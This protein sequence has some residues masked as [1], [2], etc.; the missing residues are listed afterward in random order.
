MNSLIFT[1]TCNFQGD[2]VRVFANDSNKITCGEFKDIKIRC[3]NSCM[4]LVINS[5]VL[6]SMIMQMERC[7]RRLM[8]IFLKDWL[9]LKS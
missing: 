8:A 5:Y 2:L 7:K 9:H 6:Y 1:P 3:P 4:L